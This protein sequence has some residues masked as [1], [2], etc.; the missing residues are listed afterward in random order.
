[1]VR[2][3]VLVQ[4]QGTATDCP[5]LVLEYSYDCGQTITKEAYANIWTCYST[6]GITGGS[7]IGG[8]GGGGGYGYGGHGGGG[9]GSVNIGVSAIKTIDCD[10]CHSNMLSTVPSCLIDLFGLIPIV[11]DGTK[12]LSNLQ[13]TSG[14]VKNLYYLGVDGVSAWEDYNS[15][16][17]NVRNVFKYVYSVGSYACSWIPVVNKIPFGCFDLICQGVACDVNNKEV[18]NCGQF[19]YDLGSNVGDSN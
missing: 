6:G 16:D 1:M 12:W 19:V 15:N 17:I 8:G 13:K 4:V 10:P 7:S 3:L 5:T 18:A 14:I 9:T 2:V 11:G